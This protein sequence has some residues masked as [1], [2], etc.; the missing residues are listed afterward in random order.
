MPRMWC[1]RAARGLLAATVTATVAATALGAA[2]AAMAS[3]DVPNLAGG[4]AVYDPA[5]RYLELY[6][7]GTDGDLYQKVWEPAGFPNPGSASSTHLHATLPRP[8]SP[9]S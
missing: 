2:P 5:S 9:V 6:A 3:N 7:T 1:S 8:P 4:P